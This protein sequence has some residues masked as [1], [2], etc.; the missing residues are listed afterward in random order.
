MGVWRRPRKACGRQSRSSKRVAVGLFG[1]S[2]S[3]AWSSRGGGNQRCGLIRRKPQSHAVRRKPATCHRGRRA[4]GATRTRPVVPVRNGCRDLS[5]SNRTLS[6]QQRAGRRGVAAVG[7]RGR[8][9]PKGRT[10]VGTKA[11]ASRLARLRRR[12]GER[13]ATTRTKVARAANLPQPRLGK[14]MR[15]PRQEA[16]G[17]SKAQR[18]KAL[19]ARTRLVGAFSAFIAGG[20]RGG[21]QLQEDIL[22]TAWLAAPLPYD[23]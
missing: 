17:K 15:L 23:I 3:G 12:A 11:E 21:K 20:P 1:Y 14:P 13:S 19:A 18:R 2:R 5:L 7:G 4:V 10:A 9:K 16:C 8:L 22:S 6:V